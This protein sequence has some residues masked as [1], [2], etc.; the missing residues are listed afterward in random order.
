MVC[1]TCG[2]DNPA[3]RKTCWS[4]GEVLAAGLSTPPSPARLN[5]GP[6][7]AV[8]IYGCL[9]IVAAAILLMVA[10]VGMNTGRT[11]SLTSALTA[12][13][14]AVLFGV[15]GWSILK[16]HRWAVNLVWVTTVLGAIGVLFRGLV[17]LDLFLWLTSLGLAIWYTRKRRS[18]VH[19]DQVNAELA[20][21]VSNQISAEPALS[22]QVTGSVP[23][24]A[25][26]DG[27]FPV[28]PGTIAENLQT[29]QGS[30]PALTTV[31]KV[32]STAPGNGAPAGKR[33]ATWLWMSIILGAAAV[34]AAGVLVFIPE[35][36]TLH[37]VNA[38]KELAELNYKYDTT[39]FFRA[40]SKGDTLAVRLFL[41]G[42]MSPNAPVAN[43][44]PPL[45]DLALISAAYLGHAETVK[46]LLDKGADPNSEDQFYGTAFLAAA[47]SDKDTAAIMKL[48]L[49]SGANPNKRPTE[50]PGDSSCSAS[51]L[52]VAAGSLWQSNINNL[53]YLLEM[54]A[55]V[56]S[57]SAGKSLGPNPQTPLNCAVYA[58]LAKT[59][60][61]GAVKLLLEHGA[62]VDGDA[63]WYVYDPDLWKLLRNAAQKDP[64]FWDRQK[65]APPAE[66]EFIREAMKSYE[67][68]QIARL[69]AQYRAGKLR[70]KK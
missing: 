26:A 31:H 13:F 54:G 39:S 66:L 20:D 48:L 6:S 33:I 8:T 41:E 49:Q 36:R 28:P 46:F 5:S 22:T 67:G 27:S 10:I 61:L 56:N 21:S 19:P 1:D 24:E 70:R 25:P 50:R 23:T 47:A 17:P 51:A 42:G 64:T 55:D 38:R 32:P 12:F 65:G 58:Y 44:E 2:K 3:N 52:M 7:K 40:V 15:T 43:G 14:Q 45:I 4:C 62:Q 53:N 11:T 30:E 18:L 69:F 59:N 60:N 35:L 9:Y 57:S 63:L 37:Q 29:G 16:G 68:L 34:I